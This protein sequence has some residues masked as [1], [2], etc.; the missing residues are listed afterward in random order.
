[1][2]RKR[3]HTHYLMVRKNFIFLLVTW[4][5]IFS[6]NSWVCSWV[7]M[8]HCTH[9][10]CVQV[11]VFACVYVCTGEYAMFKTTVAL[12]TTGPKR[13]QACSSWGRRVPGLWVLGFQVV[14]SCPSWPVFWDLE[15]QSSAFPNWTLTSTSTQVAMK[16]EVS[17]K[18]EMLSRRTNWWPLPHEPADLGKHTM[19][20]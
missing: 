3:H 19:V 11:Y 18:E 10:A 1:M 7:H 20:C 14:T 6:E 12:C 8:M 4:D 17:P 9:D 2:S 15:N 5:S 13:R 16:M